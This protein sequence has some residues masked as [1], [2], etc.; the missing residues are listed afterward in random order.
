MKE[1]VFSLLEKEL[2]GKIKK[3]EFEHL[4]EI[5]PSSEMGDFAFPCF[6]LAKIE[7]KSPI[8]IAEQLAEKFR[9]DLT[10]KSEISNVDAKAGYVNFFMNK[11]EMTEDVLNKILKE[12]ED[13]G[14]GKEKSKIL[15]EFSQPNTH[16]A[17]HVGH[18]RGTSLGESLARTFEF[19]GNKVIRANY[20]GDT[21]MHIAKWI[22]C[23]QKFHKNEKLI[24]D[25]SWIAGIYV[26][27]VKRLAKNEDLQK[28]VD[29]I[30]RK[31]ESKE[32]KKVN[33]IWSKTR[34]LSIKSW[35]KIYKE[36]GTYFNIH[37]FESQVELEG[38][39][40]ALELL[41]K[42]IAK[43][44]DDAVIMDL[45][46]DNLSVWVL[47][48]KDGTVLYSAKDL[49]LAIKKV[50]EF[51]ADR[52]LV[53]VGDEQALHFQQ[54]VK[55]LELMN[56]ENK[57]DYNFLTYG[58]VR[59]PTGKMSSRT[60]DNILY[61]DFM[62]EMMEYATEQIKKRYSDIKDKELKDRALKICIS[63]IKYSM[64]K[65]DPH[66]IIV[67]SKEEALNF[68]GNTGP[69]LLYSYARA[70]S[71]VKKVKKKSKEIK[72]VDL[73]EQEID[74]IKKL[75]DFPEVVKKSNRDLAP[76]LIANYIYDLAQAFNEFYHECPVL[77]SAEE[78]LRL[79][80]VEAFK[81]VMKSGLNLLGIQEIDEM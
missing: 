36:L 76:N 14:R 51:H 27:A 80:L 59:L 65:Q 60:G 19:L 38:K 53:T 47:L 49:A 10:K 29:E 45:K 58:M 61:S 79:K 4:I 23:Y 70:N 46:E 7:K 54:L 73:K 55:T 81:I 30:N 3:E 44:S 20:S 17:F 72:I 57:K 69:Y 9:K 66:K 63:A 74:L 15:I 56:F 28:E 11:R 16:K 78:G 32:D 34:E 21:G 13:Y 22:W 50:K 35:D 77:G 39:K 71:I 42:G 25:E 2:K 52:Y 12:Q 5:P 62:K 26:D 37:Y 24:N 8:L 64:L 75:G 48:R 1:I 31:I 33:E 40:I 68:D 67:F 43:K 18:I 6:A 41:D